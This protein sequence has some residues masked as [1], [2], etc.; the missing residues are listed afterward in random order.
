MKILSPIVVCLFATIACAAD[1]LPAPSDAGLTWKPLFNGKNFDGW[2][3]YLA[4]KGRNNDPDKVFQI[5]DQGEVH[6]YKDAEANTTVP[7]GYFCTDK[8]YSHYRLRFQY[9]WGEKRFKPREKTIRDAGVIYHVIGPDGAFGTWPRGNEYQVE[10]GDTGDIWAVG[11][12]VATTVEP[13]KDTKAPRFLEASQ[14]GVPGVFGD[15]KGVPHILHSNHQLEV[16][17]WNTCE[18]IVEGDRAIYILNG[19]VNNRCHNTKA[20][21]KEHPGQLTPLDHGRIL[22]QAEYAEVLYRNIEI[23]EIK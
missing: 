4:G 15:G 18:I 9:R 14:G 20:G 1:P 19:K 5:N 8:E 13:E 10:E 16:E 2:H 6:L 11:V 12:Q 21:D 3:L 23:A 17:G 22:F 7:A